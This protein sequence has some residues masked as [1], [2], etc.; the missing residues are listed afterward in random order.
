[1]G[2]IKKFENN[3]DAILNFRKA[4]EINPNFDAAYINLGN[5]FKDLKQFDDAVKNYE[6]AIEI[7]P[8]FAEAYNNF[9][10]IFVFRA[11]FMGF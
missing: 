11:P 7:N 5:V 6:R 8:N 2:L 9:G 3:K 10:N 4:I 1:M